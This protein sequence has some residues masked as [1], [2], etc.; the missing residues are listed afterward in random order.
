VAERRRYSCHVPKVLVT[1]EWDGNVRVCST[2][3]EGVKPKLAND[4][5]GNVRRKR[6][7]EIF[8]SKPYK[9]YVRAAEKCWRYDLSYPR[10]IAVMYSLNREA[11]ENFISGILWSRR[12]F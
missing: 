3:A 7:L 4:N 12:K 11:I 10:E 6:L 5:M 1:V 2:I 8:Q 9:D